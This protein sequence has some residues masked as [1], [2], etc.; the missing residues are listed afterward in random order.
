MRL[1]E[2]F[3]ET[4]F[5][6]KTERFFKLQMALLLVSSL[7]SESATSRNYDPISRHQMNAES[8]ISINKP[9]LNQTTI[10]ETNWSFLGPELA[11]IEMIETSVTGDTVF[12]AGGAHLFLSENRG[13][14]WSRRMN[15]TSIYPT[16]PLTNFAHYAHRTLYSAT[17]LGLYKSQDFGHT[18]Q[19][20]V[21]SLTVSFTAIYADTIDPNRLYA[22]T[23]R[24]D[25]SFG[26]FITSADGGL[27]WQRKN[28]GLESTSI[29]KLVR[30]PVH[31][32][33]FYACTAKGL[34]YTAN[35]GDTWVALNGNL[36]PQQILAFAISPS[37]SN[38]L[39]LGTFD[40]LYASA[41]HGEQWES[42]TPPVSLPETRAIAVQDSL[43]L[44]GTKIGVYKSE[45]LGATWRNVSSGLQNLSVTDIKVV[46]DLIYLSTM[47]GF[48]LSTDAG[49]TWE[50]RNSG[51]NG[52]GCSDLALGQG[53]LFFGTPGAGI[54]TYTEQ[55]WN[56][57]EVDESFCLI[58]DLTWSPLNQALYAGYISTFDPALGKSKSGIMIYSPQADSLSNIEMNHMY[59]SDVAPSLLEPGTL[60]VGALEGAYR[61]L[62]F[63]SSWQ[64]SGFDM[65]EFFCLR[66]SPFDANVV[67]AGVNAVLSNPDSKKGIFKSTDKA[68]SFLYRCWLVENYV[69]TASNIVFHSSSPDTLYAANSRGVLYSYDSGDN[70][71]IRNNLP[72]GEA[73]YVNTVCCHPFLG[74]TRVCRRRP[75]LCQQ[76]CRAFLAGVGRAARR[77]R[78]HW[79][80]GYR[81]GTSG[82]D[83]YRDIRKR[84]VAIHSQADARGGK[85]RA[86]HR[87]YVEK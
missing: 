28:N 71:N 48:Y 32:H 58:S 4:M 30:S 62:D 3:I 33:S 37:D 76:R 50:R 79:C 73:F 11:R 20:L 39:F 2:T 6:L 59:V 25:A 29:Y 38:R 23:Y 77:G 17:S 24:E 47:E 46:N 41:D 21:T 42:I 67:L 56:D 31:P 80:D 60:F 5:C 35:A 83:L 7:F 45:N 22:A 87:I 15:K 44:V 74:R 16:L 65:Q 84:S 49:E 72:N 10:R 36:A 64:T 51:L 69:S 34:F 70:W 14:T 13:Q 82:R 18:W 66:P 26:G 53:R 40:A 86:T 81:S 8:I 85:A 43:L 27:T 68:E 12:I 63:G 75:T 1:F 55:Q 54:Y 57:A 78:D 19:K 52:M 61:S 9:A